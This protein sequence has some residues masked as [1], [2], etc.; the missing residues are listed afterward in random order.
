MNVLVW[1]KAADTGNCLS[2]N[3]I[4]LHSICSLN[5]MIGQVY[6]HR[7]IISFVYYCVVNIGFLRAH[8]SLVSD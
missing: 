2:F 6:I 3:S 5:K 4:E 1:W 8:V 7:S